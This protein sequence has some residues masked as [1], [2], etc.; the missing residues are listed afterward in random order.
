MCN[1]QVT[2]KFIVGAAS[3][4]FHMLS[5]ISRE[6]FNR[7]ICQSGTSLCAFSMAQFMNHIDL[8]SE[9]TKSRGKN[10]KNAQE[11]S[12]FMMDAECTDIMDYFMIKGPPFPFADTLFV[13]WSVVVECKNSSH[14]IYFS[15]VKIVFNNN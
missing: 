3:V 2:K 11:L 14:N 15:L 9:F 5:P 6:L 13:P 8:V 7:G 1:L 4:N 10:L 12:E